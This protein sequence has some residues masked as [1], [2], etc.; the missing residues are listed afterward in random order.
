MT[1]TIT[2]GWWLLPLS[3]TVF[4]YIAA[5]TVQPKP[6]PGQF[7]DIGG[8]FM[9]LMAYGVATIVSLT[10]WLLWALAP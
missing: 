10:V 2:L 3:V 1:F 9:F 8:A 4:F 5:Y 6:N 7:G